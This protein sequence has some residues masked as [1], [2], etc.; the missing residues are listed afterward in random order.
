MAHRHV[1]CPRGADV[2]KYLI[3]PDAT[4][5]DASQERL[6][7][8]AGPLPCACNRLLVPAEAAPVEVVGPLLPEPDREDVAFELVDVV[9]GEAVE[10]AV[11]PRPDLRGG[12]LL[13]RMEVPQHLHAFDA[14]AGIVQVDMLKQ[15]MAAIGGLVPSFSVGVTG[16]LPPPE[17]HLRKVLHSL[18]WSCRSGRDVVNTSCSCALLLECHSIPPFGSWRRSSSA[19]M[20]RRP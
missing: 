11:E 17:Q 3:V 15:E 16:N 20:K 9:Q 19:H 18:G 8:S 6:V 5:R 7:P 12:G 14:P 13:D 4:L 1:G 10:I 2:A